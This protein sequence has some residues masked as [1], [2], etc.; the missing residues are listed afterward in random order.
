[1]AR[2]TLTRSAENTIGVILVGIADGQ[3]GQPGRLGVGRFESGFQAQI[4][5]P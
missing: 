4:L 5:M 3:R 1:M 2:M